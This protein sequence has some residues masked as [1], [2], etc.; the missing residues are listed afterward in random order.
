MHAD[1]WGCRQLGPQAEVGRRAVVAREGPLVLMGKWGL[2]SVAVRIINATGDH[3]EVAAVRGAGPRQSRMAESQD[4][5]S[6]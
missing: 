1:A 5:L 4:A 6:R 2:Q 3:Q